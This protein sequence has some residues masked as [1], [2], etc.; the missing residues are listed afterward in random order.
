MQLLFQR[1]C[2]AAN[3]TC[4]NFVELTPEWHSNKTFPCFVVLFFV[5]KSKIQNAIP[6][7]QRK[8]EISKG[9]VHYL[10]L[11]NYSFK[12]PFTS[13]KLTRIFTLWHSWHLF[14]VTLKFRSFKKEGIAK[15]SYNLGILEAC[16]LSKFGNKTLKP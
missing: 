5:C 14:F 11:N 9:R 8:N 10:I 3:Y 13:S 4:K 12:S 16:W 6:T 1:L 2:K 7:P 15:M